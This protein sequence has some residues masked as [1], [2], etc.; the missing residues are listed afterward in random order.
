M[1]SAVGLVGTRAGV[2]GEVWAA[3][4]AEGLAGTKAGALGEVWAAASDGTLG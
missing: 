3:V 1:V 2:L 4:L